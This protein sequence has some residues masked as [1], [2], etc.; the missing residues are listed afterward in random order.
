MALEDF[1][2]N[3]MVWLRWLGDGR[4]SLRIVRDGVEVHVGEMNG[5]DRNLC[6]YALSRGVK[7]TVRK[8]GFK[9]DEFFYSFYCGDPK[10]EVGTE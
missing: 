1:D 4:W 10:G 5:Y 8:L 7:K 3:N 2:D 9:P 6:D